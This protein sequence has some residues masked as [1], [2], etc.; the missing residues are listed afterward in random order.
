[1]RASRDAPTRLEMRSSQ[2]VRPCN[3]KML[4]S[5]DGHRGI[6]RCGLLET[7]TPSLDTPVSRRSPL[8]LETWSPRDE[9]PVSRRTHLETALPRILRRGH[10][11][12][13]APS[14]DAPISRRHSPCIL[15]RTHLET[16]LP[17][18]SRRGLLETTGLRVQ[19]GATECWPTLWGVGPSGRPTNMQSGDPIRLIGECMSPP[20]WRARHERSASGGG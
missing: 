20:F 8:H 2:D 10:L 5:R 3:F 16:A 13:S 17:R 19:R 4:A 12:T 9:R 1:M 15:R 14:R 7:N 6:L 11:E 18:I